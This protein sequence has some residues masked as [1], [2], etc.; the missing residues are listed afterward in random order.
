MQLVF[1]STSAAL[2]WFAQSS[3]PNLSSSDLFGINRAR[4]A[5]KGLNTN[6]RNLELLWYPFWNRAAFRVASHLDCERLTVAPQ[7]PLWRIWTHDDTQLGDINILPDEDDIIM[8]DPVNGHA[9]ND[10]GD[11]DDDFEFVDANQTIST[12]NETLSVKTR[13][14]ITDFAM[15]LWLENDTTNSDKDDED[16]EIFVIVK[17]FIPVLIEI[18]RSPSRR[19]TGAEL[20]K[21][22]GKIMIHAQETV[23]R[24]VIYI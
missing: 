8:D 22:R 21:A 17:E 19:L 23:F 4:A 2:K 18:K 1:P 5:A 11:P 6:P 13:S 12:I 16:D 7:F 20:E 15:V 3:M 14:R 9:V 10:E 24:Q